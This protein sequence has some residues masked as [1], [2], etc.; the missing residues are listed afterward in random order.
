M[1]KPRRGG[2]RAQREAL[3]RERV[4][5]QAASGQSIAE[6]CRGEGITAAS[7]YMWRS[8]HRARCVTSVAAPA[9][10]QVRAS[11]ID[12]GNIGRVLAG[13]DEAASASAGR[14]ELCPGGHPNS[15]TCGH[16][17]FLHLSV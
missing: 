7:F 10:S 9:E 1:S 14:I 12:V 11:F 8:R 3:W 5:R 16:F 6:F 15:S 13:A 4:R 2:A 17:K